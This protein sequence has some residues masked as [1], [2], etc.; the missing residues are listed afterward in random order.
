LAQVAQ[1]GNRGPISGN[2]QG[3][4]GRGSE[5]P[6]LVEDTP[7]HCGGIGL[8][9]LSRSLPTQNLLWFYDAM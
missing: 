2:R 9:D 7:A 5:R 3:Q 6:G 8:V 4:V 1:R